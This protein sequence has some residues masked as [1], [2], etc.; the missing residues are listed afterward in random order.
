MPGGSI[1]GAPK[2]RAMQIIDE[3]EPVRRGP[4]TG[5]IGYIHGDTACFN[6]AIRTLLIESGTD[7]ASRGRGHV[8]YSVGGGIVADSTPAGEYEESL[9]KAQAMLRALSASQKQQPSHSA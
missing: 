4:Y 5:A 1:T 7:D 3:L 9:V 8:D 2:V 6:I